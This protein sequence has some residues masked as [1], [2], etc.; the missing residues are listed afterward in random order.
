LSRRAT[1]LST[2]AAWLVAATAAAAGA[3]AVFE[4]ADL[5]LRLT[6]DAGA[7][8]DRADGNEDVVLSGTK[9]GVRL[10][11]VVRRGERLP[12]AQHRYRLMSYFPGEW[13]KT[14]EECRGKGW[15]GCE[16][17]TWKS[18]SGGLEGLGM[19]G[20]GPG[21]TYILVLSAKESRFRDLRPAMRAVQDSLELF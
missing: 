20:W 1:A 18:E 10:E 11:A 14:G 7:R 5:G 21:G 2:A 6:W 17:W 9:G 4:Y 16:S 15:D 8:I 3:T 12:A 13:A 19:V